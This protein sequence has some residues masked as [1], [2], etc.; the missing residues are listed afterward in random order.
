MDVIAAMAIRTLLAL[1]VAACAFTAIGIWA[2]PNVYQRLH[3]VAVAATLG[4]AAIVTALV[5]REGVSQLGI[6]AMLTG[7]VV[8]LM[9][10]VLSHATARAYR[11]HRHG[12]W[13][14]EGN[15]RVPMARDK[16]TS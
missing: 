13:T 6:K 3:Y 4:I 12:R 9:N 7:I 14:P 2:A 11:I 8:I 5:V 16:A 1:G 10:P 15:E